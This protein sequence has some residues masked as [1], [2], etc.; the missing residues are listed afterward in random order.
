LEGGFDA[1]FGARPLK[2]YLQ[3]HAQTLLAKTILQGKL[4]AGATLVLDAKEGELIC[5]VE[6]ERSLQG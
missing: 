5:D 2:R 4:S 1:A 3:S 6:E